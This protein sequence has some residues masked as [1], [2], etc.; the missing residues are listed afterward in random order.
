MKITLLNEN[1]AGINNYDKCLAEWGLSLFLQI[2]NTNILFDTGQSKVYWQNAKNL[3]IDLNKTDY[4]ILSHYHCDHAKG[5]LNHEFDEKKKLIIHPDVL[6]KIPSEDAEKFKNDFVITL[7]KEPLEFASNIFYLGEIPRKNNFEKGGY[8]N[9]K[10][11]DDSAL[12][13]K[14]SKGAVVITGCSH[15]GICNICEYAKQVTG[16]KL[17]AVIGGFHLFENDSKAVD[18]TIVYFKNEQVEILF[19]MHCVD[20]PVLARFY[21]EFGIHKYSTGDSIE[22]ED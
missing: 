7:T 6:N 16:Q 13:I 21:N 3:G 15:S 5:L 11:L 19:P 20:F 17:Y 10:M 14:S 2:N 4:I 8:G 22:L 1:Q 9:D 12:A 18:S